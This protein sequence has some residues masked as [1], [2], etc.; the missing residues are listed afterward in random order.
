MKKKA[1]LEI[2]ANIEA[3]NLVGKSIEIPVE[4]A[5]AII[6]YIYGYDMPTIVDVKEINYILKNEVPKINL[7]EGVL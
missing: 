3:K 6:K 7:Q 1:E 5:R 4:K 2:I